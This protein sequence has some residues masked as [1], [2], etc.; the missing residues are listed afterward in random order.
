MRITDKHILFWDNEFSNFYPYVNKSV[1]TNDVKP[2]NIKAFGKTFPTSEHLF[3]YLKAIEFGDKES[4]NLILRAKRPEEAKRIGRSVKGFDKDIWDE[5][6]F[7]CMKFA[8]MQKFTQD[9]RLKKYILSERFDNKNFVEASPFD[10]IWGIGIH[11]S[12][13]NADDE[14][15]WRG[16]N[17][18]GKVLDE[19]RNEIIQNE[20]K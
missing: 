5:K 6:C 12:D 14:S 13:K 4:A 10:L 15:K 18:L 17:K 7:E 2:L 19:V 1:K 3:M 20:S 9:E 16:E 11:Y 8:V